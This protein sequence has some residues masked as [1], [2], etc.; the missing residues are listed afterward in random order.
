MP[1]KLPLPGIRLATKTGLSLAS[2]LSSSAVAPRRPPFHPRSGV[3]S[4][5]PAPR[6]K[7]TMGRSGYDTTNMKV[8]AKPRPAGN[9]TA[10]TT[11]ITTTT[12]NIGSGP[13][14]GRAAAGTG[15]VLPRAPGGGGQS[16]GMSTTGQ[17]GQGQ[18]GHGESSWS[19]DVV[20]AYI[21]STLKYI[22][23]YIYIYTR[24]RG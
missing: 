7:A 21:S 23:S 4:A 24:G 5:P 8:A 18:Q 22:Y 10:T 3:P 13:G 14:A 20:G 9:T 16:K 11:T 19:G 15:V 1:P 17:S 6:Q 12:K 2:S